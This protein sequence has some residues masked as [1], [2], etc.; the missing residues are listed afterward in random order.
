MVQDP[1]I[2]AALLRPRQ[3]LNY[4]LRE[5]AREGFVELVEERRK[6]N[7]MERMARCYLI[8]PRVMGRLG[9]TPAE[10]RDCVSAGD[11]QIAGRV[12]SGI[13]VT[14]RVESEVFWA[15]PRVFTD[16]S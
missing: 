7:G 8:S 11:S 15:E 2:A 13:E 14:R 10:T 16:L 4:H 3:K 5:T 12:P 6:G 1:R 9:Q